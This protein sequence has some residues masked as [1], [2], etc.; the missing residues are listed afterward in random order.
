MYHAK[1]THTA[2]SWQQTRSAWIEYLSPPLAK[3]FSLNILA[4]A[5]PSL[6]CVGINLL[7]RTWNTYYHDHCKDKLK[8]Q[9][10][11]W[12]NSLNQVDKQIENTW[13]SAARKEV[14]QP[15]KQQCNVDIYRDRIQSSSWIYSK[16]CFSINLSNKSITVSKQKLHHFRIFASD[17]LLHTPY[18]AMSKVRKNICDLPLKEITL[19]NPRFKNSL[20][21]RCL[22]NIVS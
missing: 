22:Q 1:H 18:M 2:T 20:N 5:P 12:I 16:H 14:S 8:E 19:C 21:M 7:L 9:L 13:I 3:K 4:L 15:F 6:W 17:T 11:L 10:S